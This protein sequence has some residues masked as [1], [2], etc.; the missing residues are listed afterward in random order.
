MWA[1]AARSDIFVLRWIRDHPIVDVFAP[2]GN[3][4]VFA[5]LLG[6]DHVLNDH[7]LQLQLVGQLVDR[8]VH[9]VSLTVKVVFNVLEDSTCLFILLE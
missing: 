1:L 4:L 5:V 6:R 2:L 3:L 7:V 8:V 9:V